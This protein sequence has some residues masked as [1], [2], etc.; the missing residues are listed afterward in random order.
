MPCKDRNGGESYVFLG[1]KLGGN[2]RSNR[3]WKR[4]RWVKEEAVAER[5][6]KDYEYGCPERAQSMP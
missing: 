1:K 5:A 4:P 2:Y 6:S 3:Q